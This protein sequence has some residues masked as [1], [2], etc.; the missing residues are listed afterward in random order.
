[1]GSRVVIGPRF[2]GGG[3][4]PRA[5]YIGLGGYFGF[6]G[7]WGYPYYANWGLPYY[8]SVSYA[9]YP[10]PP[11]PVVTPNVIRREI[12]NPRMLYRAADYYLIAFT[13]KTIRAA[14]SYTVE[15]DQIRWVTLEHEEMTAPLSTVDRR[16][17]EQINRDRGVRFLLP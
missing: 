12:P 17:S 2:S 14:L 9:P 3:F 13:D 6:G 10:P 5:N 8:S 15:G 1:V 4:Y 11:P 16:F 7:A